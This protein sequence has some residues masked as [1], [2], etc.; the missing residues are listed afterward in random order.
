MRRPKPTACE[1]VAAALNEKGVPSDHGGPWTEDDVAKI[2]DRMAPLTNVLMQDRE[3]TAAMQPTM[4][5]MW[6]AIEKQ[7]AKH[8]LKAK[9]SH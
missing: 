3:F 4:N 7:A 2:Y 9:P 5:E 8:G 6:P 1:L